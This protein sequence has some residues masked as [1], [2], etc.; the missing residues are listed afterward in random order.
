MIKLNDDTHN[1]LKK[2]ASYEDTMDDVIKRLLKA[3]Q[4]KKGGKG[5]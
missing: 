5:S 1:Q 3:Y 2:M 4:D